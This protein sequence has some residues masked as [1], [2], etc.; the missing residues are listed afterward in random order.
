APDC[1]SPRLL[2]KPL[3]VAAV[4]Y[5]AHDAA[6]SADEERLAVGS[7][8]ES[9]RVFFRADGVGR[10]ANEQCLEAPFVEGVA[11]ILLLGGEVPDH[12]IAAGLRTRGDELGVGRKERMGEAGDAHVQLPLGLERGSV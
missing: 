12:D 9:Y 6:V 10:G 8:G 3:D 2:A 4:F 7:K 1:Y 11:A 5:Q